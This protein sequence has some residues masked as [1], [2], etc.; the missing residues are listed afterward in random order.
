MTST[1][2]KEEINLL[3]TTETTPNGI[4]PAEVGGMLEN[5]VDYVD[6]EASK[7]FLE[8]RFWLT[9][10]SGTLTVESIRNDFEGNTFTLTVPTAGRIEIA[11]S[12]PVLTASKVDLQNSS[13]L[14]SS[15]GYFCRYVAATT[16]LGYIYFTRYDNDTSTNPS[17]TRRVF[18]L[19]VYL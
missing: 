2:I 11:S 1:E 18:S 6:Q 12:N 9:F 17:F 15:G 8:Y 4:T 19:K 5:I 16:S 13:V 3:I 10:S 7:G 14:T